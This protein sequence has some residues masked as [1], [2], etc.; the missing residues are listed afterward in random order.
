[1]VSLVFMLL[2]VVALLINGSVWSI[3]WVAI[4]CLLSWV[5]STCAFLFHMLTLDGR[6]AATV[7]GTITLG[8]GGWVPA[9]LLVFFFLS[10]AVMG[11][12][13][14]GTSSGSG[15]LDERRNGH[16]VWANGIWVACLSILFDY[17]G[18]PLFALFLICALAV[19]TADTWASLFGQARSGPAWH[20]VRFQRVDPGEEGGV[21][22]A[23]S[24][25]GTF[26]TVLFG[27][28]AM[29]W[30]PLSTGPVFWSVVIGGMAGCITD[31]LLGEW[32]VAHR[33]HRKQ[34]N[35]QRRNGMAVN[36]WINAS[37]TAIGIGVSMVVWFGGS[38]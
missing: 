7:L 9:F 23:G 27:I 28:A 13:L 11:R 16:Q 4:S 29:C 26:A 35:E 1:M 22:M 24:I 20:L 5:V 2:L 33:D 30:I 12:V 21:S 19:V 17:T 38:V 3:S 14:T 37:S 18:N 31:S 34:N 6:R 8:L 25:A 15:S 10:S 32:H 36:D